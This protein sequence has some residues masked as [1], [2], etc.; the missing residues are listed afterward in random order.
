MAMGTLYAL[1]PS[2]STFDKRTAKLKIQTWFYNHYDCPHRQLIWFT[3]RWSAQNAF[4]HENKAEIMELTKDICGDVPGSQAF[5]G[6]LK[7]ATTRLW[8]KLSSQEQVKFRALAKEWSDDRPPNHVQAK[9]EWN[10]SIDGGRAFSD[11]YPNWRD[12]RMWLEWMGYATA[13]FEKAPKATLFGHLRTKKDQIPITTDANGSPEL[14]SVTADDG[15]HECY[16]EGFSWADPSKLQ[17]SQTYTLLNHWRK[18]EAEGMVP[19][20]WNPSC[21]ILN[22]GELCSENVR[23]CGR[24]QSTS[25]PEPELPPSRS[26]SFAE[27]GSGKWPFDNSSGEEN[28]ENELGK[29]SDNSS[30]NDS[31]SCRSVPLSHYPDQRQTTQDMPEPEWSPSTPLLVQEQSPQFYSSHRNPSDASISKAPPIEDINTTRLSTGPSEHTEK[32]CPRTSFLRRHNQ[33][34]PQPVPNTTVLVEPSQAVRRSTQSIKLTEKGRS[35]LALPID[36]SDI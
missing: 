33:R 27:D 31:I 17:M 10:K 5:F 35:S 9:D 23:G 16:P 8:K 28:F 14:P 32:R 12:S 15:Y 22:G 29:I 7:D 34:S 25:S 3:R 20:I 18:R 19:L 36:G 24:Q 6:A 2:G 11:F 13:C 26:G 1:R 30:R 4:Y 21:E